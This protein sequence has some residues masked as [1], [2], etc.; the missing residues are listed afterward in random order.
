MSGGLRVEAIEEPAGFSA[1]APMWTALLDRAARPTLFLTP[2][3]LGTWWQHFGGDARLRLLAV[4]DGDALAGLA[5]LRIAPHVLGTGYRV[6]SLEFLGTG[7]PVWSDDMDVLAERGREPEVLGAVA[8][9][10]LARRADW[11]VAALAELPE[12][13]MT[14]ATLAERLA[15]A[16]LECETVDSIACPYLRLGEP[17]ETYEAHAHRKFRDLKKYLKALERAGAVFGRVE[18]AAT[19]DRMLTALIELNL[20]RVESKADVPSLSRPAFQDFVRAISR[21]CLDR[22]WLRLY[23]VTVGDAVIGVN[24]NFAYGGRAYG[25]LSG[26]DPEWQRHGIGTCLFRHA[27][28]DCWES[29]LAVYDFLRGEEPYKY[30]WTSEQRRPR[31]LRVVNRRARWAVFRA[32]GYAERV[33]T[34]L[35]LEARGRL[36]RV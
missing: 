26:F 25:Y 18:D 22:G 27:I 19:L 10:L 2:E 35:W 32:T 3:W 16:G 34:R 8:E 21:L 17:W 9:S 20:K 14:L 33:A 36:A 1:L 15:A 31:S 4:R 7:S 28:R 13:S 5:P 23:W 30:R 24:L 11:D 12:T 6:R 29:R